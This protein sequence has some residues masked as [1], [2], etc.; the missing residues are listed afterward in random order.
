MVMLISLF[1]LLLKAAKPNYKYN[2][3]QDFDMNG[4]EKGDLNAQ[5]YIKW[6]I[7]KE[8]EH[9]GLGYTQGQDEQ[10]R[11]YFQYVLPDGSTPEGLYE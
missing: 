11:I 3:G 5:L 8:I 4:F 10:R 7:Q 9:I 6:S 2:H 1:D